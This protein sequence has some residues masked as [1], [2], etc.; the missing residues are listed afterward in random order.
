MSEFL[1]G[2][3]G[4]A[5]YYVGKYIDYLHET[6]KDNHFHIFGEPFEALPPK[7][8]PNEHPLG[9]PAE[10]SE[11]VDWLAYADNA[12]FVDWTFVNE[13]NRIFDTAMAYACGEE[14]DRVAS[15][16]VQVLY[17]ET[18][19]TFYKYGKRLEE[20]IKKVVSEADY[21]KAIG[22][23]DAQRKAVYR[24]INQKLRD[25]LIRFGIARLAEDCEYHPEWNCN[26]NNEPIHY[27]R[28]E[29]YQVR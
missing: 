9:A 1:Y 20:E 8:I 3:Y 12:G 17:Y 25:Q 6:A 27:W 5:G 24:E 22:F 18:I 13:S 14:K 19:L 7:I 15:S 11:K 4:T 29:D 10:I 16:R 28:E 21:E 23:A 2:Y 26:L